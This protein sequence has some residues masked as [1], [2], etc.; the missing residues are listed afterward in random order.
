MPSLVTGVP[1]PCDFRVSPLGWDS[2][3][4]L[5]RITKQSASDALHSPSPTTDRGVRRRATPSVMEP[6]SM[7]SEDLN[8][9]EHAIKGHLSEGALEEYSLDKLAD[10]S[11]A[12]VEEHLLI[13][14]QRS[15]EHT[16][17]L[18]SL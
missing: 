8:A 10:S 13:C 6:Q 5:T 1:L 7:P 11:L 15:E 2:W 16:S 17:E 4:H 12:A 18:Q 9:V 14:R 3:G